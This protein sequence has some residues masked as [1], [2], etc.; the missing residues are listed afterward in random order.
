MLIVNFTTINIQLAINFDLNK[1]D[2]FVTSALRQSVS[3]YFTQSC[4]QSSTVRNK[5]TVHKGVV[6]GNKYCA[7]CM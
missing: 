1:L 2:F 5:I 4:I 3:A 6:H 7:V